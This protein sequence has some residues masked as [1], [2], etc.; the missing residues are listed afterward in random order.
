MGQQVPEAEA[1]S[2][3]PETGQDGEGDVTPSEA[4]ATIQN[5]SEMSI[6]ADGNMSKDNKSTPQN[7]PGYPYK[8]SISRQ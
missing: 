8:N 7:I 3:I 1:K 4:R 6:E 5:G 2:S